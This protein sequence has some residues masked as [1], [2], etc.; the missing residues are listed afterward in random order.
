M[1]TKG[2][3]GESFFRVRLIIILALAAAVGG[4]VVG[5]RIEWRELT[6]GQR[7]TVYQFEL[8]Y[9]LTRF[10]SCVAPHMPHW[11]ASR[12]E[13][14]NGLMQVSVG[15]EYLLPRV[16]RVLIFYPAAA[17]IGITVLA[18]VALAFR[19]A[20]FKKLDEYTPR[21]HFKERRFVAL[22]DYGAVAMTFGGMLGVLLTQRLEWILLTLCGLTILGYG[23]L[24]NRRAGRHIRGTQIA[25]PDDVVEAARKIYG[26]TGLGGLHI[27]GI[28]VP[29]S[30][31]PLNFLFVGG[32][33]TGKS[34]T[35][36]HLIAAA[37]E[38]GDRVFCSDPRGDY[39]RRFWRPGDIILNPR[40]RRAAPW[41]PLAEIHDE[42]DAALIARSLVPDAEGNDA[43]WHRFAQ[44]L[45]EAVLLYSLEAG[46]C[47]REVARLVLLA[48]LDE[49]RERLQ[50]TPAAGLLPEKLDTPMFHSIRGSATPYV[51]ALA[52]L[53]PDAGAKAFSLRAWARDAQSAAWWN[54]Q[55]AQIA[56]LRTLIGTQLDLLALGVLEQ[57]DDPARRTWLVIDELAAI[58]RI[59]MLEDFLARARKAGGCAILGIQSISQLRRTYGRDSADALL[60]C[61]ASVLALALGDTESKEYVSKTFGEQEIAVVTRSSGQ[62]D[63]GAHAT[64]ARQLRTQPVIMPSELDT[65]VLQARHG[66]LK[67][68]GGRLPIAPVR[69]QW[70]SWPDVVAR[71]EPKPDAPP[72]DAQ[73]PITAGLPAPPTLPVANTFPMPEVLDEAPAGSN[74]EP[75]VLPPVDPGASPEA[76]LD[77]LE[78]RRD[79]TWAAAAKTPPEAEA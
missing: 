79:A 65:S 62:A 22:V 72:P 18:V 52:W 1:S 10:H 28:P 68:A 50:G 45:V 54:Y 48:S 26:R 14:Y 13:T 6:A 44:L 34:I 17:A 32:P 61:T 33:G 77:Q 24:A 19:S 11:I 60:T 47:N 38:R 71:F 5:N 4:L 69:L 43:S 59:P 63:A 8:G 16:R 74:M 9:V 27:A 76:L 40:D 21:D 23:L 57:P 64:I 29:R 66:F 36:A 35:I 53:A 42:A 75:P 2:A 51:R 7:P 3:V 56:G 67:L 31:E 37:R 73:S 20:R 15:R 12:C 39:L 30:I 25:P 55:D 70:G 78:A 58:G 49:L 41:S 46:L